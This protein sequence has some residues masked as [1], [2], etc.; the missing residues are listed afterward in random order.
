MDS[1]DF[2]EFS[3][4]PL[5][6]VSA[7]DADPIRL[8]D[9][10]QMHFQKVL[11]ALE[12]RFAPGTPGGMPFWKKDLVFDR[13]RAAHDLPP[14]EE[15]RRLAYLVD[16]YRAPISHD[17]A[18]RGHDLSSLW[19]ERRWTLL[20]D[21]LDRLPSHSWYSVSVTEDEEHAAMLAERLAAEPPSEGEN[22][23]PSLSSWTPEVAV[24]TG[25]LDAVRRVEY[26]VIAAQAGSKAAGQP[27]KPS[28]RPVTPLERA[29]KRADFERR[30]AKH[31]A[32]V[33]RVLRNR[34]K[35]EEPVH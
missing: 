17:L 1:I 14:F 29:L 21:I 8:P 5:T 3:G 13:W 20:L 16:H 9:P 31:E 32:L 27:P 18:L 12:G 6:L 10:R 30:K 4:G 2:L 23:G 25:V 19:R 34:P 22:A 7:A 15:A 11:E 26:A 33:A 28:P 24:L 35:P